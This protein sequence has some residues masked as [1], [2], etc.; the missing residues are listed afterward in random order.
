[1]RAIGL[2]RWGGPE[3][4]S[5]VELPDP[6]PG[7]GEVLVRVRAAAVNPTDT[8]LR[9][10]ARA[11]RL[12][13]VPAP[14]VPGMDAAGEVAALGPATATELSVGQAVMA[15]VVP[16]GPHGAYAELVAVPADSVVPIPVGASLAEAATLP[17]NGLTATMALDRLA[18]RPGQTL[19]V[20]GAAGTLGGYVIELAKVDRL[21]VVAD[22][23]PGDEA[24]VRR[25]GADDVVPR[26]P[27][28]AVRMRAVVPGGVDGLVDAAV[29][30]A[31]VAGAVRD[32]GQV[33]TVRGFEA[34]ADRGVRFRPVW[35]REYA[36]EC[37]KLD[38]LRQLVEDGRLHLRVA[39]TYPAAAAA[40]A[41]RALEAGGVRG[42]LVLEW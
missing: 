12:R 38:R 34:D 5:V 6:A 14:H 13:D 23:A 2:E 36:R 7:P 37:S 39:R 30:N 41:H 27:D 24:L 42:R 15:V 28:V 20:T 40:D 18:L 35:V 22:A 29:Q 4:L 33:A 19:G 8:A 10:G 31:V 11:D 3:V 9:S 25:L 32:G 26:G 21:R 1:V 17:M 16:R